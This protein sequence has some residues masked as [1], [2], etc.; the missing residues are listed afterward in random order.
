M[1][2]VVILSVFNGFSEQLRNVH[3]SFDP[4]IMI[5]PKSG[6]T[7]PVTS[8]LISKIK[9]V[10]GINVVTE[11][12]EDDVY[13]TYKGNQRIARFKGVTANYT[14]QNALDS[15]LIEGKTQLNKWI[16]D[17]GNS[18]RDSFQSDSIEV[19]FAIVGVGLQ[20]ELGIATLDKF[21]PL[22]LFYPKRDKIISST[23]SLTRINVQPGGVFQIERQY[24]D[25]YLFIPISIAELLTN[26]K[27]NRTSLEVKT[28][29]EASLENVADALKSTLGPSFNILT[30][31]EQHASL[32]RAIK[33]E[34]LVAY[35]VFV[36]VLLI[37]CLNLY[38]A[39][40]MMVVSKKQDI[41]ILYAMG[42]PKKTIQQ[43]FFAE[44]ILI[45]LLGTGLGLF[46]GW[47]I[48]FLQGNYEIVPLGIDSA[49]INAFPIDMRLSDFIIT[50]ATTLSAAIL[51]SIRPIL[52]AANVDVKN[53][54]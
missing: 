32:Y 21:N 34:K 13:V 47:G 33:I 44:S 19:D 54:L 10:E 35:L 1:A 50:G 25:H 39:V 26:N 29:D 22:Q 12:L 30:S 41:A 51:I 3:T 45:A 11:V 40:S 8:A 16:D 23:N 49:I 48:G 24:D 6:K 4:E 27:G 9:A 42:A 52:K 53:Q 18:H 36:I 28:S 14:Q 37:A 31:D 20:Y 5:V 43:I 15:V 38:I 46:L 17:T 7:F 2:L